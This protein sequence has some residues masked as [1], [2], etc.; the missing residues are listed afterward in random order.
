MKKITAVI[1]VLVGFFITLAVIHNNNLLKI[2]PY[3]ISVHWFIVSTYTILGIAGYLLYKK[4]KKSNYDTKNVELCVVSK[5]SYSV[6]DVLFHNIEYHSKIFNDY[7]INL[8]VDADGQLNG[9]LKKYVGQF[10]NVR[11][12]EVPK[13]FKTNAVAKGRAIEWFIRFHVDRDKWY[14]FIDDDNLLADREFL[15]LS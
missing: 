13:N 14:A 7:T 3:A 12:L 5:A 8:I 15:P 4:T 2:I 9:F 6:K 10:L 1:L 11:Y